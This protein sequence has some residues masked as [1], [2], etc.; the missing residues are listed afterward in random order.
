MKFFENIKIL[1][2]FCEEYRH[3]TFLYYPD[4]CHETTIMQVIKQRLSDYFYSWIFNSIQF[5]EL[6]P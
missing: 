2:E 4:K 5:D 3:F 6:H 1:D